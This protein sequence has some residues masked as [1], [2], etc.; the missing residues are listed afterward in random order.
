MHDMSALTRSMQT[1]FATFYIEVK[2]TVKLYH[3]AFQLHIGLSQIIHMTRVFVY[4]S[5]AVACS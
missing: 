2:Y 5:T 4:N 1:T 3:K